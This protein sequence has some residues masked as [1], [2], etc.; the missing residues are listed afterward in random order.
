MISIDV[1]DNGVGF[2]PSD[3]RSRLSRGMLGMRERAYLLG[4]TLSVASVPGAGTTLEVRIPV[5]D[6][7]DAS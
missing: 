1:R 4:G 2:R 3:E 6:A 7:I 5:G